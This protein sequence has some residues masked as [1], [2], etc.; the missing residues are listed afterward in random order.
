[1]ILFH[2]HKKIVILIDDRFFIVLDSSFYSL[3]V[4]NKILFSIQK[5]VRKEDISIYV[6]VYCLERSI[7]SG[8]GN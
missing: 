5:K 1:M 8:S 6:I 4:E 3:S 7:L 2:F